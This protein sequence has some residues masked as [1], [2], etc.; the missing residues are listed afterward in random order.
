L[1][2]LLPR[3]ASLATFS[4]LEKAHGADRRESQKRPSEGLL[5]PGRFDAARFILELSTSLMQLPGGKVGLGFSARSRECP[6]K[7]SVDIFTDELLNFFLTVLLKL[8]QQR[9][10]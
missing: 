1:V 5:A 2:V 7:W 8:T 4:T 9:I 3:F 10:T 6:A